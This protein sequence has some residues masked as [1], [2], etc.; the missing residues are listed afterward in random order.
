MFL[1]QETPELVFDSGGAHLGVTPVDSK[2]LVLAVN[3]RG[4]FL[5]NQP[6]KGKLISVYS[7]N[8]SLLRQFGEL[9]TLSHAYPE[10][11]D[12]E[13]YRVPLSRIQMV[14]DPQDN[15]YVCYSFAPIVQKYDYSGNLVWERRLAGR[16]VDFLVD[17]FWNDPKTVYTKNVDGIQMSVICADIARDSATGAL[18]ILLG[19]RAICLAN[20]F[21]DSLQVA[22][23]VEPGPALRSI[24]VENGEVYAND[25]MFC[26]KID[27]VDPQ[28]TN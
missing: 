1:T 26:F 4:E 27:F 9:M 17:K 15:V 6:V 18:Y 7:Q 12:D 28:T 22:R 8:G 14:T 16:D 24:T 21:V 25:R 10:R 20:E 19:N 3:S 11:A 23:D 2:S 5:L 13:K